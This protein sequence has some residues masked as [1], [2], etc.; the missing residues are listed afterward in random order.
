MKDMKVAN[1]EYAYGFGDPE[2]PKSDWNK[3]QDICCFKHVE[4]CE[5]IVYLGP[6]FEYRQEI[7]K[8]DMSLDFVQECNRAS[9][10]GYEY[11]CFY[12]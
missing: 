3:I 12:A 6:N 4:A 1:I 9:S 10:M 8:A 7:L 11:A 2:D 5:F